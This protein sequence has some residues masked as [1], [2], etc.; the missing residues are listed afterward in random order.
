MST[1]RVKETFP[2]VGQK[3]LFKVTKMFRSMINK[4]LMLSNAHIQETMFMSDPL[5]WTVK[6]LKTAA[7]NEIKPKAVVELLIS[8]P[9]LQ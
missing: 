3:V 8:L 6:G 7:V 1:Y 4:A 2:N 9:Y 5:M